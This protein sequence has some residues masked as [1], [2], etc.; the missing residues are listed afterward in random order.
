[1]ATVDY[2]AVQ[3][4]L[5][6]LGA[7]PPLTVDGVYGPMS[8]NSVMN[9]QR[10]KGL[11]VDGVVGPQTLAALGLGSGLSP[12]TA[13]V[14]PV[15][16]INPDNIHIKAKAAADAIPGLTAAENAFMR[17]VGWHETNY[18][19]GWGSTPPPNGGAG[20]FNMGAI[21][22]TTPGP[23]DF[24]HVDSRNDTGEVVQ[25][26]T[27]FKGYPSFQ[28]GMQGLADTVLKP[29]VKAAIAANK[30]P[31]KAFAAGVQAMYDNH[32]FLGIHPRNTAAGNAQN[33]ADYMTAVTNAFS[34]ISANT[35]EVLTA[36][37]IGGLAVTILGLIGWGAWKFFS[38]S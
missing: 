19:T 30:D 12:A 29:N 22:T 1:M 33:V 38:R 32:Y 27:W 14:T 24:Q 8:K 25:Y 3:T 37:G 36:A 11:T 26:V 7:N 34:T 31:K 28:A 2:K 21:T 6:A 4:R 23:L 5:N 10:S 18:G 17:S 16:S 35:G 9:F 20:S 15:K 13:A